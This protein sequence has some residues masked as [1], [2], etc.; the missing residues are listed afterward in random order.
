MWDINIRIF[1]QHARDYLMLR[2]FWR[3]RLPV[4]ALL[5]VRPQDLEPFITGGPLK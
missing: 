3:V 5:N 2:R 1:E 4:S